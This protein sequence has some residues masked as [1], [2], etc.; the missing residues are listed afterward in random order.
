MIAH[1]NQVPQD[2]E[3]PGGTG[4]AQ[5]QFHLLKDVAQIRKATAQRQF[6]DARARCEAASAQVQRLE[7]DQSEFM[8]Q[9]TQAAKAALDALTSTPA[10][11]SEVACWAADSTDRRHERARRQQMLDAARA[12]QKQAQAVLEASRLALRRAAIKQEKWTEA[13]E[14][15]ELAGSS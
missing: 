11:P 6:Q 7:R 3:E 1:P 2:P 8:L 13:I 14:R 9:A 12:Q 15:S 5:R 4:M 10:S